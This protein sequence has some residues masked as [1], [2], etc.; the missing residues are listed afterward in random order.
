VTDQAAW[1]HQRRTFER[2]ADAYD[3][4]RPRYPEAVFDDIR[5][6]ADLAADD[7]RILEI[8]CGT[9]RA[10]IHMAPWPHRITALEPAEAMA[11]I[12]RLHLASYD[13]IEIL[14]TT[15]ERWPLELNTFGLVLCSLSFH[16]LDPATRIERIA[17]ALYA[18]GTAAIF[19]DVQVVTPETLPFF[20]RVQELYLEHAPGLAHR[21]DFRTAETIQLH[22]FDRSTRFEDVEQFG[23]PWNWTLSSEDYVNLLATH[24]SHATLD[25]AVRGKL[26]DGIAKLVDDEFGGAVTEHYVALVALA[27]RA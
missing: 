3:R 9:G 4:F 20:E 22:R 24:S 21:G 11:D 1:E 7:D 15:F 19:D 12:A 13:N 25:D 2:T 17:D 6:Y 16:W 10:T 18:H 8:G 14:T 23:H 27:R 5:R 26:H